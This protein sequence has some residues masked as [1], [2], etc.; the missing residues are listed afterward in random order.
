MA[1]GKSLGKFFGEE[2]AK[3]S[4]ELGFSVPQRKVSSPEMMLLNIMTLSKTP[5]ISFAL[6]MIKFFVLLAKRCAERM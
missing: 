2:A 5:L 4:E 6:L 3:P 1:W